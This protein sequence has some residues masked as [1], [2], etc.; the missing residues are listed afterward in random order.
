MTI[1]ETLIAAALFP[2]VA[3]LILSAAY[4]CRFDSPIWQAVM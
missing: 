4:W 1:R 3:V 2:V